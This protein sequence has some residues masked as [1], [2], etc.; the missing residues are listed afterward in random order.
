MTILDDI[1]PAGKGF[2][3]FDYGNYL[4]NDKRF[5]SV[6]GFRSILEEFTNIVPIWISPGLDT[7]TGW[8]EER[9]YYKG[10]E[11]LFVEKR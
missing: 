4:V 1:L 3:F 6:S 11:I 5:L 10:Q 8:E 9:I 7:L 2:L